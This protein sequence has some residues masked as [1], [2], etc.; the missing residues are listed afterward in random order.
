M[1]E[2]AQPLLVRYWLLNAP[3]RRCS[4]QQLPRQGVRFSLYLWRFKKFGRSST[5]CPLRV[6]ALID[7]DAF[8]AQCETVRLGLPPDQPLCVQQW[9]AVIALNYAAKAAG[10]KRIISPDE[11]RLRCPE[12]VLQHV[13]TWREGDSSWAYRPDVRQHM[14]TDKAVLD[15]YRLQSR[16]AFDLIKSKLT[17]SPIQR[18]EKASIDEVFLDLS[19]QVH[20]TIIWRYPDLF[21]SVETQDDD[22]PLPLLPTS[23]LDWL[24][25]KVIAVEAEAE[26]DPPDGDDVSINV[27]SEIV[28]AIRREIASELKYTYSAGIARNKSLAKLAAG[29]NKPNQQTVVRTRA[30]HAFIRVQ[31]HQDSW[32]RRKARSAGCEGF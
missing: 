3:S 9:N 7:F 12:V 30:L 27:G 15:P 32:S 10:L 13:A 14:K 4:L 20:E 21:A 26:L 19:A 2:R 5:T 22:A 6:I 28:R 11:A 8:Y 1:F 16:K 24:T 17:P 31:V 29:C 18:V 25:D 23:I